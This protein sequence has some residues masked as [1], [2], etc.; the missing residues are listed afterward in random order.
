MSKPR[1]VQINDI[2]FNMKTN[3]IAGKALVHAL[4]TAEELNVPLF[5]DG[6]L[7]DTKAILRAECVTNIIGI[8]ESA[9]V[10]VFVNVGNHD[11]I[12]HHSSVHSLEFL[13]PYATIIQEPVYVQELKAIVI[14]YQHDVEKLKEFL[15]IVR[16]GKKITNLLL[17]HQGIKGAFLGDYV[18]DKTSID[19]AELADFAVISGHYHRR[20][21]IVTDGRKH[22]SYFGVGTFNFT[23]SP[24]TI[25]FTEAN[26]E[27]KGFSIVNED[28]S[29]TPVKTNLRKHIIVERYIQDVMD[30]IEGLNQDDLLWLKVSGT[31]IE[32]DQLDKAA[33]SKAHGHKSFK[34]DKISTDVEKAEIDTDK[35]TNDE[36]LD[37]IIDKENETPEQKEYLRCLW[38]ELVQ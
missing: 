4:Q 18:I 14:P 1:F 26:D 11:L 12:N 6:D 21:S 34:L 24:Y 31:S 13:R 22:D 7:N 36:A 27:L 3:N 10:P 8:L 29:I 28:L 30:P 16:K 32:L 33:L 20:Q 37:S 5:I 17:M 19:P 35:C 25:T 23:G 9:K 2:H 15:S 38:R